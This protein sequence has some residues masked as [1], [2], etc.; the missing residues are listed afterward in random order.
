MKIQEL[1]AQASTPVT[2]KSSSMEQAQHRDEFVTAIRNVPETS[3]EQKDSIVTILIKW[4]LTNSREMS[5]SHHHRPDTQHLLKSLHYGI[6]W[7]QR[8]E[9]TISF[10]A[11]GAQTLQF[12]RNPRINDD[13]L[14]PD[15]QVYHDI[16]WF[17]CLSDAVNHALYLRVAHSFKFNSMFENSHGSYFIFN[18]LIRGS[19]QGSPV[20][21]GQRARI[22]HLTAP[23]NSQRDH[24]VLHVRVL[25]KHHGLGSR[26]FNVRSVKGG[27]HHQC[28]CQSTSSFTNRSASPLVG[29]FISH[30]HHGQHS[31]SSHRKGSQLRQEITHSHRVNSIFR[32]R[33]QISG[34]LS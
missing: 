9:G 2:R 21:T 6:P 8:T 28:S 7:I 18:D 15:Q 19:L 22:N 11:I 4:A 3:F 12:I 34:L 25:H 1:N 10:S 23:Y 31:G 26:H 32:I 13:Q 27:R 20:K 29:G 24:E 17:N 14:P 33:V 16:M 30:E 5:W